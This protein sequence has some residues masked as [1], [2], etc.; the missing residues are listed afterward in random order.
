MYP[1]LTGSVTQII[2]SQEI[3]MRKP[4]VNAYEKVCTMIGFEP[5]RIAFFD[6]LA[7]NVAG[8]RRAGLNAH[9]VPTFADTQHSINELALFG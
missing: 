1:E 5:H 3:G 8:A 7:D 6:D 4:S 2:C 9:H